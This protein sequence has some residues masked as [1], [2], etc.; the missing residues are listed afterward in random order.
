MPEDVLGEVGGEHHLA[1]GFQ[2]VPE[3]VPPV[4]QEVLPLVHEDG[5]VAGRQRVGIVPDRLGHD[6]WQLDI[7][8][9]P[10]CVH[11]PECR[12]LVQTAGVR[13]DPLAPLV[14]AQPRDAGVVHTERGGCAP[15]VGDERVVEARDEDV[16]AVTRQLG[17]T[18][19]EHERLARPGGSP[20]AAETGVGAGCDQFPLARRE[21]Y[22]FG[23]DEFRRTNEP[24][25]QPWDG[26]RRG[27]PRQHRAGVEPVR[28][29]LVA[30]ISTA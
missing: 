14:E 18:P 20:D 28:P 15:E 17:S 9:L 5:V 3:G 21:R 7:A 1:A 25:A 24:F 30:E 10:P 13:H 2:D 11:L 26:V 22:R 6:S 19:C 12:V 4:G 27:P 23:R 16:F 29:D 8:I